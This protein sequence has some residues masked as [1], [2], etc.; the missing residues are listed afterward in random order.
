[1]GYA[2]VKE[3]VDQAEV[4]VVEVSDCNLPLELDV[5][6]ALGLEELFGS[7][8]F[9]TANSPSICSVAYADVVIPEPLLTDRT[10]LDVSAPELELISEE[11]VP[12]KP[13]VHFP[14]LVTPEHDKLI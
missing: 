8:N 11:L 4:T 6:H 7:L 12:A 1:M 14:A 2:A 3:V 10:I 5:E 9:G 13:V